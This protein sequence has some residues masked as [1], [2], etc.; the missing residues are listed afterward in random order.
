MINNCHFWNVENMLRSINCQKSLI[1]SGSDDKPRE[2]MSNSEWASLWIDRFL[3]SS[4]RSYILYRPALIAQAGKTSF[5]RK[6]NLMFL[7]FFPLL[8]RAHI[9]FDSHLYRPCRNINPHE[10]CSATGDVSAGVYD[11]WSVECWTPRG[12]N[13]VLPPRCPSR[14]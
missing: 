4:P 6:M 10:M 13:N 8:Y 7:S 12:V 5:R 1:E 3:S 2:I 14:L 11:E 9:I